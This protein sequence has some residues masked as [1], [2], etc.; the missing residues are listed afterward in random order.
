MID[1][2]SCTSAARSSAGRSMSRSARRRFLNSSN[3]S[4]KGPLPR[5]KTTSP[6]IWTKRRYESYAKRGF[7]EPA[8]S[9]STVASFKPRLRMVS[10]IP[11]IETAAPERTDTSSGFLGSPNFFLLT[12]SSCFRWRSTSSR[13]SSGK[14]PGRAQHAVERQITERIYAQVLADLLDTVVR[15][16][17]LLLAGR[18]D[19]VIA[20]PGDRRR[21]HA[22]MHLR[23]T[24]LTD[25]L[26]QRPARGPTHDRVVHH[27][28][29]FPLEHAPHRVELDLHL[30]H[31]V[32]LRGMDE[33]AAHVMVT[34]QGMLELDA[35][36]LRE[37]QRHG[38]G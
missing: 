23:G 5:S 26:D 15:R 16:D 29:P 18:V 27:H 20:R 21:R 30:G 28:D 25:Q 33:G 13:I 31:A 3:P 34:D 9:P 32:R 6:Y 17:Q 4:A 1:L 8:I 2:N 35:R 12:R 38:V 10:I 19:A 36:L 37:A 11:G 7:L 24:G 14:A 22:E